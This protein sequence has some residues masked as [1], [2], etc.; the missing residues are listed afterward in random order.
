[1]KQTT[2][3]LI[4]GALLLA[5]TGC[6]NQKASGGIQISPAQLSKGDTL[7]ITVTDFTGKYDRAPWV[8]ILDTDQQFT[9]EVDADEHDIWYA[10]LY[11]DDHGPYQVVIGEDVELEP[12][13][14]GVVLTDTDDDDGVVLAYTRFE[15]K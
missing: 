8:G 9:K 4:S 12:G 6:G 14:Y 11:E 10:T 15:V 3:F 7:T 2:A 13:R 1:M 5:M